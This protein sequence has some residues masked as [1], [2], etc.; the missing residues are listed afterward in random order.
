MVTVARF[1]T[2]NGYHQVMLLVKSVRSHKI[3]CAYQLE[4]ARAQLD[5]IPAI[6]AALQDRLV[7]ILDA[8]I[9]RAADNSVRTMHHASPKNRA[10]TRLSSGNSGPLKTWSGMRV[11]SSAIRG[12]A[13]AR[14]ARACVEVS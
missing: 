11:G 8:G 9:R 12:S 5:V 3:H 7:L 2:P 1:M 14:R 6:R 10:L 4:R 13:L